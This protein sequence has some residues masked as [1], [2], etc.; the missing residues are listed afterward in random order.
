MAAYGV[1]ATINFGSFARS[2]SRQLAGKCRESESEQRTPCGRR[3]HNALDA[4]EMP[5]VQS[6][7]ASGYISHVILSLARIQCRRRTT[8]L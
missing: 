7:W 4:A 3:G 2:K 8:H 1:R 6:R 5:G